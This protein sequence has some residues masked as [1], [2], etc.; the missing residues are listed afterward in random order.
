MSAPTTIGPPPTPTRTD[1]EPFRPAHLTRPEHLRTAAR[2]AGWI[3]LVVVCYELSEFGEALG[4]PAPDLLAGLLAGLV[5]ALSGLVNRSFPRAAT[6]ASQALVGV[7][8]GSYLD[9]GSAIPVG[10]ALP[11]VAITAATILLSLGAAAVLAR[12]GKLGMTDAT[13]GMVPGGSAA[14][15][16]CSDD[17]GAD[18]RLV[19]F[20]QYARVGLVAT[21]APAVVMGF[22]AIGTRQPDD[23]AVQS[24][25]PM[26][27]R[28]VTEPANQAG[29][30]V[31]LVAVCMVGVSVGRHLRLP[32]PLLLGPM[33]V[34]ALFAVTDAS[35]GFIPDGPLKDIVFVVVGLE[36]GLRFTRRSVRHAAGVLHHILAAI[37]VVCLACAGL[38]WLLGALVGIP[39]IEAYLATTPGGIN[40]V[41]AT[42]EST[43]TNVPLVSTVQGLRLFVVCLAVPPIIRWLDAARRRAAERAGDTDR[44]PV[45]A[46]T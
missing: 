7:I 41:L 15:I 11:L 18:S 9:T 32:A 24:L 5:L 29:R 14:I 31:V 27:D 42:A 30:L 26:L 36:V 3:L 4:A 33:V 44:Q 13:L 12:I 45:G 34:T 8:M 17:L 25:L 40:A 28:L 1:P 6:R 23:A 2:G 19:A 37:A 35:S 21:T 22:A 38:A 46:T 10:A 43:G 20:A 39:F 16:S